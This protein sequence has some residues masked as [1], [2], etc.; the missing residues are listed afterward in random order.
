MFDECKISLG[1]RFT[2]TIVTWTIY[3]IVSLN[4]GDSLLLDKLE[5]D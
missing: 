2:A 3:L 1:V 5:N 4:I